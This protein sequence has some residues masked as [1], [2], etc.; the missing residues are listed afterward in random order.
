MMKTLW[1]K[2]G[3][4]KGSYTIPHIQ[5]SNHFIARANFVDR[6]GE[7]AELRL[8]NNRTLVDYVKT[9]SAANPSAD[10]GPLA[11]GEYSLCISE[12][13]ST[14]SVISESSFSQIG[15]GTVIAALGDSITEGY[16]G[17]GFWRES[18]EL[19]PDVFPASV[20]SKDKRNYPQFSPTTET[21]CP[22]FNCFA[23]WMPELN[24]RLAQKWKQ[25]VFIA[26]EGIGGITTAGYLTM[27]KENEGW[28][29]R[30]R[31]LRP[32]FWLLHLGVNDERAK[33]EAHSVATCLNA[34]VDLLIQDFAAIPAHILIALPSYDYAPGA[35]DYLTAYCTEIT[36]LIST[37]GLSKGPDFFSAYTRD[38]DKYYGGDPVHP[39]AA[40]M[41]LMAQLWAE[42]LPPHPGQ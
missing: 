17:H 7:K 42:A 39:N 25:P 29:E 33:V 32:T 22:Q 13:D 24:D 21:H 8:T 4:I 23:S 9:V 34:I 16:H 3:D 15:I 36:H 31:Q 38:K 37:R 10:F 18:L 2:I 19:T 5:S 11:A 12:T 20:V 40:G 6:R 1:L 27:M 35:T 30:M 28:Q 26:N 14:G 41:D